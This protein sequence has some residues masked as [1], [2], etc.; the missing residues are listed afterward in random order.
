MAKKI[1]VDAEICI[2]CGHCEAVARDYF[3]LNKDGKSEVI[4]EYNE[5][6]EAAIDE[7][8]RGCPVEAISI[9]EEG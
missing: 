1:M 7:A 9:S 5:K 8:Y 4:K 3:K 6:D 2:G